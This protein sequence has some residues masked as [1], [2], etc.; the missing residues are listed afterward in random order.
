[1]SQLFLEILG[2]V[3]GLAILIVGA[4]LL[5]RGAAQLARVLGLSPFAIGVTVVAFGTSA[6]ELFASIGAAL[7]DVEELAIGNVVGSN[8][9][10]ILLI[11]GAGAII[12]PIGI[13]RRVRLVEL[14][15]MLVI[16]GLTVGLLLDSKLT[17][18][19]GA[20]LA[21]GLIGY[22]VFIVRSHRVE[23]EH[24]GDEVV[25]H[26]KS[27]WL[28]VGM[29]VLGIVALGLGARA[30]VFGA[31]GVALRV[32]VSEGIVG[33]TVVA[34]GTSLPELAATIRS[35]MA[36]QS[37][38]A[39]GN[40]VGSNIF[41]LLSVL[42]IT[43]MIHPLVASPSMEMHLWIMLSVSVLMVVFAMIRP[44]MGR[45][46]GMCF[47]LLYGAYIAFAFVV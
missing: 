7:L 29:V 13:H 32:G 19:D 26:P 47:L 22:V 27:A 39:V 42:G 23:I 14:P 5:V 17:R 20:L 3:A 46:V 1:M 10:N 11:L 31:T 25:T 30:L 34:L 21:A 43:A 33:T 28:D 6:P 37:D 18:V 15:I 40:V 44:A 41:N 12:A 45:L 16:T 35:V 2:L 38:I 4:D 8:I 24:E 36:K 9:A